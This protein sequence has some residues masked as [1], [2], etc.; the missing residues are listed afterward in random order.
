MKESN[1][2]IEISIEKIGQKY[3]HLR[4]IRPKAE[5]ALV[6]SFEQYG[7]VSPVIVSQVSKDQYEMIDG[8]KRLRAGRQLSYQTLRARV[9]DGGSRSIKAAMLHF[10]SKSNSMTELEQGLVICSLHREEGL[11]QI[12]IATLMGRHKS[13]VCRRLSI[14]ER[15]CDEVLENLKIGL[16]NITT[17]RELA[18]LPRGNQPNV[19]KTILKYRFTSAETARLVSILMRAP[20]W[21]HETILNFPEE[22]LSDRQPDRPR[23]K[24]ADSV[25]EKLMKIELMLASKVFSPSDLS[26]FSVV[27]LERITAL[28]T[29]IETFLNRLKAKFDVTF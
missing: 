16:I 12:E 2:S 8:F 25:C 9:F 3:S 21:N 10:N 23:A 14:V 13:W 17:G 7:Q 4:I 18:R 24:P 5:A 15:L 22:I 11:N 19:L 28:I 26:G 6:R 20:R 27:E 1:E 29:S